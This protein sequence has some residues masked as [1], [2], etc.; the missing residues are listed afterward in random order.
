MDGGFLQETSVPS[1]TID[2]LDPG[3]GYFVEV[4]PVGPDGTRFD[5]LPGATLTTNG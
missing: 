2:G 4:V 5:C 1:V 3:T